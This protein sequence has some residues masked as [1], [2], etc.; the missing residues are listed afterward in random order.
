MRIRHGRATVTGSIWTRKSGTRSPRTLQVRDARSR[1]GGPDGSGSGVVRRLILVR[2]APTAATRS[3]A[4]PADEPL[5][6]RGI[7]AAAE[8]SAPARAEVVCSPS[9]RCRATAEAAGLTIGVDRAGDRRVRL[10]LVVRAHAGRA[11]RRAPCRHAALDDRSRQRAAR[12]REPA[13]VHGACG[14]VARRAGAP[15]RNVPSRSPT[16]A[17]SRR[18]SST[19]SGR[20]SRRSGASTARRWRGPSCTPMTGRWTLTR[21]STSRRRAAGDAADATVRRRRVAGMSGAALVGGYA[22]DAVFGDPRRLH[23]VA[24]FGKVALAAERVGYAPSRAARRALRVRA[25]WPRR[26]SPPSSARAPPSA[27]GWDAPA[28]W[29]SSPGRRSAGARSAA[30]RARLARR[31]EAGD[32]DGARAV[33]PSL[34]GRDP[35]GLDA[36]GP[37]PRGGR[38]GGREHRRRRRR[39]AALGRGR[40]PGRRRRATAPPTRSTRWSATAAS[41]TRRSAGP[42]RASTTS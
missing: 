35:A 18:R 30:R 29:P 32:L 8:L 26:R 42:R 25:S 11:G 3:Y 38:V 6:E 40:R 16:A 7:A 31:V 20:R 27:L 39:R 33:L 14:R 22:A 15:G 36:R 24:G 4:F 23:P 37:E 10:R 41:A 12:R 19:R 28:S 34:C 17:S 5:D 1:G 21:A 9:A 2:H 13:R